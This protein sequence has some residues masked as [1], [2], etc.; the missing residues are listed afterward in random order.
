MPLLA[1]AR[2]G[3]TIRI[4]GRAGDRDVLDIEAPNVEAGR[5]RSAGKEVLS[6]ALIDARNHTLRWIA[7]SELT[8]TETPGI[9]FTKTNYRASSN[10]QTCYR[11]TGFNLQFC[12]DSNFVAN[13][14]FSADPNG[15]VQ[16]VEAEA[17]CG[18]GDC[19]TYTDI[20][21]CP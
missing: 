1:S 12:C 8:R 20:G 10:T 18:S 6:L 16:P 2:A 4:E 14:H 3:L 15:H 21:T 17:C 11:T 9:Q 13:E 19:C 7:A 5:M